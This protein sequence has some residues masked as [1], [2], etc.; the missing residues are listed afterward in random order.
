MSPSPSPPTPSPPPPSPS[1][2]STDT[3]QPPLKKAKVSNA[4]GKKKMPEDTFKNNI[5]GKQKSM[6]AFFGKSS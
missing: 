3:E 4:M 6:T 5:P 1:P 2:P